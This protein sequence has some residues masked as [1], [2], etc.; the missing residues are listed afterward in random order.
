M[1]NNI[2]F[3]NSMQNNSIITNK[4]KRNLLII[5]GVL[6]V[7]IIGICLFFVF[8]KKIIINQMTNK[9]KLYKK[10][11]KIQKVH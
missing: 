1:N 4:S 11:L 5:S 8:N 2:D 7:V 9:L 6:V 3:N 10:T